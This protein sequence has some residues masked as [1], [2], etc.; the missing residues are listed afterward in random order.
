MPKRAGGDL[1]RAALVAILVV[2]LDST[3]WLL[4]REV[5]T[6]FQVDLYNSALATGAWG[7]CR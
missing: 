7:G 4:D 1:Q 6:P 5:V 3:T 2:I